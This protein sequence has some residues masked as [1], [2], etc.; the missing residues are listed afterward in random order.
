M[1]PV[2]IVLALAAAV[3]FFTLTTIVKKLLY[4][5]QP[6]EALIFSGRV[7]RVGHKEVGYRVV[8]GGRALRVPLFE[9]VDSVELT[10]IA[11]DIEVRGAYSKGGIPLHVHGVA[12]VKLPGEEPLLN[13]AVERFLGKPRQELMRIAKETLEGNLRGV[14]AQLT[15]E[16]VNQDKTR[17]AH[18]LL[19]E[20]E[21]DLN[22]MGLVLDTLK[23]QN[24]TD[25]VG[26]LNSIGRIQGAHVRM[27]AAVAEA[28]AS[29]DA[30]VQQAHN[31][32]AS[33]VAKVDADLAIARQETD[34]RIA[35]ARTRREALIAESQ[36]EVQAE[37]AQVT[38]EIERQK[39]RALQVQ[40]RLEADIVQV[41]EADRRAREEEA[42]GFAA[43][44]IE[45]GKAEAAALKSVFEAYTFAGEGAREVLALQQIIPL[46]NQVAGAGQKLVVDKVTVLPAT[47]G[48]AGGGFAKVAISASEQIKAATGLDLPAIAKRLEGGAKP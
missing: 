28:K 16:E 45:R 44:L 41:A 27:E 19:E 1:T 23:I 33:E 24:I 36:G 15:P 34:K 14:L 8:R 43:S 11:I 25:D 46:V 17:F 42:R 31:W 10:N 37:V 3:V 35:D 13:N 21:H 22:R 4:V 6:N 2:L 39:A 38:A 40:R 48:E 32:A 7:R 9:L 18:T 47:N 30:Q 5:S 26:Y 12:N 29:A 20:A